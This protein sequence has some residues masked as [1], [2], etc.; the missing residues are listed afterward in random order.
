MVEQTRNTL[1]RLT[2]PPGQSAPRPTMAPAATLTPKE[3]LAIV[4]RHILLIV[5]CSFFGVM[6]AG[7]LWYFL[8]KYYPKYTATTYI[9]V[10]SPT[11]TDPTQLTQQA[12]SKDILYQTR[13]SKALLITQQ[14][15]FDQL[16]K[17][18]AV[19]NTMW[20]Q[21]F[22]GSITEMMDNLK[23]NLGAAA[24]R[25]SDYVAV[26]MTCGSPKE[27]ALIVNSMVD[28]F[29]NNQRTGASAD[30][31][32]QLGEL[33]AQKTAIETDLKSNQAALD[34]LRVAAAR[35]GITQLSATGND[36]DRSTVTL[37]LNDLTVQKTKLLADIQEIQ[38]NIGTLEQLATGPISVQV[39]H[40]IEN[41]PI[42]LNLGQQLSNLEAEMAR[43]LSKFGENHKT[44][45]QMRDQLKQTRE[46]RNTR[47]MQI[48]EQT[49]QANW[50]NSQ[51]QLVFLKS[52]LDEVEKNRAEAEAKQKDLDYQRSKFEAMTTLRD[53]RQKRLDEINIQIEKVNMMRTDRDVAKVIKMGDAPEPLQISSPDW[54]VFFPGGFILGLFAGV[55][56]A[57]LKE[58]LNDLVRTPS[59]VAKYLRIPLLGMI[60]NADEDDDLA[61]SADLCHVVRQSPYS[62]I[63]ESYRQV[64]SN[65][66]LSG[67]PE[68]TK[69]ILVT[70]AMSGEGKTS[71]A[72][73]LA[74]TLLTED[75]RV[76][77]I[78]ANF[79]RPTS[80]KMFPSGNAVVYPGL[81]ALLTGQ[82][83]IKDA[84]RPTQIAALDVIDCGLLPPSPTELFENVRMRRVLEELRKNYDNIIIDGPPML[85]VS[86]AKILSALVDGTLLV[87]NATITK[88]GMAMRMLRELREINGTI[89]GCVLFNVKALKGG[90]FH[91]S[92]RLYREYQDVQVAHTI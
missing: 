78:D 26:S 18:D 86:D 47:Q 40:Q 66:R 68:S 35:E 46:E 55:G 15:S 11:R 20:F 90:Y 53:E 61:A 91:E 30:I 72:V 5:L 51:D 34:E 64:R 69:T 14:N 28:L 25:D 87:V 19:R 74:A 8:L 54:K 22:D 79:R 12:P 43:L 48:G 49:R 27:S 75:K 7:G 89:L 85:L 4:R 41:D 17:L 33:R 36:S 44:V 62:I 23:K 70:S 71:T 42:M 92:F 16:L 77:L 83:G 45:L 84:I 81:S 52:R 29:V 88:R 2:A 32:A 80:L 39:D 50:R 82:C 37:R 3:I 6:L 76:L 9:S 58:L 38:A 57:F 31:L 59:D 24:Q 73:N 13:L 60:P 56:M 1:S 21:S 67:P 65:L 10:L 63:S